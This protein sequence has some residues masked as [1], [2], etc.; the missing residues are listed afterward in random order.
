MSLCWRSYLILAAVAVVGVAGQ[1]LGGL[2]AVLWLLPAAIWLGA[3]LWEARWSLAGAGL[4]SDYVVPDAAMLGRPVEARFR[5]ENTGAYRAQL[6][7]QPWFP[8]GCQGANTRLW[9]M[10]APGSGDDLHLRLTPLRLGLVEPPTL[11]LRRKGAMGLSWWRQ[12]P[13]P[14][15]GPLRILPARLEQ[16][17]TAPGIS[18]QGALARERAGSGPDF[19]GLREYRP[20]DP[21]RGIDWKATARSGRRVVRTFT[22]ERGAELLLV[23]DLG[24]GSGLQSG[25]LSHLHHYVNAA[26]R[27]AELA[28]SV[29]DRCGLLAFADEVHLRLAPVRGNQGLQR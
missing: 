2:W 7:V 11:Y 26:S 23:L 14:P 17:G 10:L 24:Y 4:R 20:G 3:L 19:L 16:G 15:P 1:W 13:V 21:L 27:L 6:E 18:R 29:G 8:E 25:P 5:M 28:T 22:E 9:L 12:S